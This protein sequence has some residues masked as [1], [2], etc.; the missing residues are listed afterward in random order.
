MSAGPLMTKRT[1]VFFATSAG[2]L[3]AGLGTAILASFLGVQDLSLLGNG[4][5]G[6]L[7]YVPSDARAVAFANVRAVMDSELRRKLTALHGNTS[8]GAARFQ[9]DTGIDLE[10]DVD[11]VLMSLGATDDGGVPGRP[12]VLVRGRFDSPRLEGAAIAQGAS[13]EE[14]KSRRILVHPGSGFA[15]AFVEPALVAVGAAA[16]IRRA[17]DTRDGGGSATGNAELMGLVKDVEDGTAWA[18]AR[19]DALSEAGRIPPELA[20]RIPPV[21]W[22]AARG[23][24]DGGLHGLVRVEARDEKAAQDLRDVVRGFVALARLQSS[25]HA[26]LAGLLDSLE[27]TGEGT[28]VSLEFSA[29]PELFDALGALRNQALAP[30]AN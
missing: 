18:V 25:S 4:G 6:D 20:G 3:A 27:L 13:V 2:V 30:P 5:L 19:L 10:H 26:Q 22:L 23:H 29:P 16:S 9:Q 17:I 24:V 15:L 7:Q 11:Q 28:T 8:D 14:Y 1:R 21:T 12:L